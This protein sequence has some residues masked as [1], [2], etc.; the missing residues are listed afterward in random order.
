MLSKISNS[1]DVTK[2]CI[3]HTSLHTIYVIRYGFARCFCWRKV[4]TLFIKGVC[5]IPNL[6]KTILIMRAEPAHQSQVGLVWFCQVACRKWER[7][8]FSVET[9]QFCW[10][11][12]IPIDMVKKTWIRWIRWLA[13]STLNIQPKNTD[14][15]MRTRW[16]VQLQHKEWP[17]GSRRS[18]QVIGNMIHFHSDPYYSTVLEPL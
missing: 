16:C 18:Q 5:S 3:I 12:C 9:W 8:H 6:Y 11:V 13:I 15:G 1:G 2:W 7:W 4:S 10:A 17:G 14:R